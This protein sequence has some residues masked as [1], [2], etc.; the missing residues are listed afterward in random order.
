[1]SE[2]VHRPTLTDTEK[3]AIDAEMRHYEK[4]GAVSVE[5]LRI[6]QAERGWVSDEA[7]RAVA[8]YTGIP[9]ANLEGVATFYNLVFR[10]PVGR[11]V[12]LVCDSVSCW[13][14]GY[15]GLKQ[16]VQDKLGI[17]FGETT[18]DGRFTLLPTVCIG[19]CDKAPALMIDD[20]HY[21]QLDEAGLEGVLARY[22]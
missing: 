21:G 10:Q 17:G 9:E 13:L 12:V 6:V 8:E 14:C 15:D 20:D 4:P 16:Q 22:T 5:A 7:L 11:H 1:M 2:K 19:Y 3:R 18:E